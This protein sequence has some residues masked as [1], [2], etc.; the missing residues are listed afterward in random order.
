MARVMLAV[1]AR[2]ASCAY[3]NCSMCAP[4]THST[5]ATCSAPSS[6]RQR[7]SRCAVSGVLY[8]SLP[9]RFPMSSCSGVNIDERYAS[10][11]NAQTLANSCSG[12]VTKALVANLQV[13]S[14]VTR[15][16]RAQIALQ[17]GAFRTALRFGFKSAVRQEPRPSGSPSIRISR[18]PSVSSS[19]TTEREASVLLDELEQGRGN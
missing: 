7:P 1:E 11:M 18:S 5:W 6:L 4:T 8:L 2:G 15:P 3:P 9:M 12:C 17:P 16:A 19:S 14:P 10:P 13:S